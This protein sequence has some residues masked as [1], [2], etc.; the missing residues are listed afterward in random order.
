[1]LRRSAE[2]VVW[3]EGCA[4]A[5]AS[6]PPSGVPGPLA[7]LLRLA[8]GAQAAQVVY[9]AAKLDLADLLKK[10]PLSV[11]ELAAAVGAQ[12]AI[13][14]RVLRSLVSLGVF[15]EVSGDRFGLTE[16]GQYLRSDRP[17]SVQPRAILN[18]E[19]LEPLWSEFLH[20]LRTGESGVQ[21]V[22]GMPLYEY[23]SAHPEVGA[24]F[25]RTMATYARSRL[26]PAV[27]A[28]DF[29]QFGT[30]VDVGGGNGALLIEILR[31]YPQPRGIVFDLPAVAERAREHI[32]AAGL[33]DRCTAV[34]GSAFETVPQGGDAYV[35]CNFLITFDDE[36]AAGILRR[37]REAMVDGGTV[38]LIEWVVP[39][40]G[41]TTDPFRFWDTATIDLTIL[42]TGSGRVRTAEEL[43]AVL[44][45]GG[46]TLT[47]I[48]P[49]A[50]SVCVIAARPA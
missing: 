38:L 47:E 16:V 14:R 1:M 43:Q 11:T 30:I 8:Y 4:M 25:D 2:L 45:A 10:G 31:A 49:T 6:D 44:Q 46:L 26:R 37:C 40:A 5:G 48:I 50:S 22:L 36:R 34:G 24:L 9:L 3:S 18:T 41:E 27:A 32:A 7:E 42:S 28:Y 29:G 13:L 19:V 39:A 20:T 21:R 12:P 35:L 15:V 17:D 33:A 23:L